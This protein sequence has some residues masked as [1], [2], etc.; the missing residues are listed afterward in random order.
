MFQRGPSIF[1]RILFVLVLIG[2]LA[3][4]GAMLFRAGMAQ[5]YAQGYTLGAANA[6]QSD[7]TRATPAPGITTPGQMP[8][9]PGYYPYWGGWGWRPHFFPF[10]LGPLFFFGLIFFI[11][12]VFGGLFRGWRH[13]GYYGPMGPGPHPGYGPW[14]PWQGPE[15]PDQPKEAGKETPQSND[16][17]KEPGA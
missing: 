10:F 14:G 15:G 6:A 7:G 2:L 8:F 1:I 5:G 13:R 16:Q 11:F 4:A 12:I 3:G 9:Y 17:P